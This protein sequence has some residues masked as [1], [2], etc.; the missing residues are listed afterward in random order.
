MIVAKALELP[1]E[2]ES[3]AE[4]GYLLSCADIIGCHAE[5]KTVGQAL[6]NLYDVAGVLYELCQE[7]KL[8]FVTGHAN[9]SLADIVWKVAIPLAKAA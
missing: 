4:G 5:G 8:S 3:L 9:I 2:I 7:K 6:D 1:V